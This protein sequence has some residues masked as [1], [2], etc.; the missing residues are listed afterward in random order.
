M[1]Q[2]E[3]LKSVTLSVVQRA[4][5]QVFAGLVVGGWITQDQATSLLLIIAG[6]VGS[7]IIYAYTYF[8]NKAAQKLADKQIEVALDSSSATPVSVVK[9]KAAAEVAQ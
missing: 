1:E 7:V 8:K 4:L 5:A 3:L 6:V 2:N 9:T